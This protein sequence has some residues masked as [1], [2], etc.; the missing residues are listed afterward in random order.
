MKYTADRLREVAAKSHSV[1]E[2]MRH[3]GLRFAGGSHTYI[4]KLLR[5]FEIDT[6][7]FTG[8]ASN[9]GSAH[10]G[11]AEK[12]HWGDVLVLRTAQVREQAFRLRRALLES[13]MPYICVACAGGPE[14]CGK[15][16]R[17]QV[18]HKNGNYQDCRR[19]N[20]EFLC[21]NCHSQTAGWCGTR[22]LTSLTANAEAFR[23]RRKRRC[24]GTR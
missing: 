18:N 9:Q 8:Q 13:G 21:P 3:L 23:D 4:S 6:T 2:V 22:G 14:W 11:G 19:E 16:L 12:L 17:L 15:E 24:G 10:R 7:H 20:L 5:K 1:T